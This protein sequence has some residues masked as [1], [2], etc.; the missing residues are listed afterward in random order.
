MATSTATVTVTVLCPECEPDWQPTGETRCHNCLVENQMEDGCGNS[1]W[2]ATD[3]A[4]TCGDAYNPSLPPVPALWGCVEESEKWRVRL[5]EFHVLHQ[6]SNQDVKCLELR[7]DRVVN[8]AK[9]CGIAEFAYCWPKG[10][11]MFLLPPG[12]YD[13]YVPAHSVYPL[14]V[15]TE[16]E[17]DIVL[18]PVSSDYVAA[19]GTLAGSK[20]S[21]C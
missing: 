19:L 8:C 15:G 21:C 4:C 10:C 16:V 3:E 14:E 6:R 1:R 9:E 7:V 18:E 12:M 20:N 5:T 17:L 13:I 11:H 2:D